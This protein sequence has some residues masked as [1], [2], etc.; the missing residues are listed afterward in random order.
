MIITMLFALP[1]NMNVVQA[2]TNITINQKMKK[3]DK[4]YK[5]GFN[6]YRKENNLK[7]LRNDN[8]LVRAA[9]TRAKEL[10]KSFSHN[11][12][13]N[14]SLIKLCDRTGA[15]R[16]KKY[17]EIIIKLKIGDKKVLNSENL[18]IISE[19]SLAAWKTSRSHDMAIKGDYEFVGTGFFVDN[20]EGALFVCTIFAS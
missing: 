16:H 11:R 14:K 2:K 12:P 10:S 3:F 13:Q 15:K 19:K 5:K 18:E 6:C 9:K 8:G 17:A 7:K 4:E 20:K 1:M